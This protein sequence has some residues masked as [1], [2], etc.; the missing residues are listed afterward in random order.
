MAERRNLGEILMS[1][2]RITEEDTTRALRYQRDHGGY[3]GEA[4][5]AL[6]LVSPEELEW[7]LA[8]QFDL[9]YAFPDVDS[10][11]PQAAAL[12]SPEWALAHL[13][14]PIMRT[15]QTLTVLVDAPNRTAGVEELRRRTDRD[16]ELALASAS[17]IRELIRG[18]Y[19]RLEEDAGPGRPVSLEEAFAL[20]L[21]AAAE[22]FGISARG[23]RAWFWYEDGGMRRRRRLEGLWEQELDRLVSPPPGE[24]AGSS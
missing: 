24:R 5:L 23:H 16:V 19:A 3:F 6:G 15:S 20:A 12:V 7:G 11:D 13:T 9:P 8:S 17:K 14:L 22:R 18:V 1:S 2:G 10:I 4:L 21:G